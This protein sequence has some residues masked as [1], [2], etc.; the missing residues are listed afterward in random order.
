MKLKSK[1]ISLKEYIPSGKPSLSQFEIKE[2]PL[3]LQKNNDVLVL[4]KW[5][6]VDPYMRARMTERKNYKPPFQIGRPMEGA[7][8]GEIAQ[9][10]SPKFKIGEIVI[11][12]YGWRDN[13]ITQD[14]NLKK[15]NPIDVPLQT[16]LGPLGFTGHTAYIGLF[17]I[18]KIKK[19]TNSS[20]FFCSRKR[21]F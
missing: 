12:N 16:Y 5:I 13:F 3:L 7:A 2:E 19:K 8:I 4:N 21:G 17:K 10:N 14:I 6:S 18:A 11:S 1:F 9:S 15:I 20:C